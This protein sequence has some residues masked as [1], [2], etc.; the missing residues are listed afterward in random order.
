MTK[1]AAFFFGTLLFFVRFFFTG[2]DR[3]PAYKLYA[4]TETIS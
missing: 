1:P 3:K 2:A 4:F